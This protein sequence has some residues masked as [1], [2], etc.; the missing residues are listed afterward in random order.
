MREIIIN[1]IIVVFPL[2]IYFIYS[3]NDKILDLKT[4]NLLF[5]FCLFSSI[6]LLFNT[7]INIYLFLNVFLLISYYK[8]KNILS[9]IISIIIILYNINYNI[10]LIPFYIIIYLLYYLIYKNNKKYLSYIIIIT[11]ILIFIILNGINI[12]N[13]NIILS[14]IL[15]NILLIKLLNKID[16]IFN[17]YKSLDDIYNNKIITSSLF[18]ITHEIKNPLS[19]IKGYLDMYDISNINHSKK[20]IPIIKEEVDRT[21]LLL[22]DFLCINKLNMD[23]DILDINYLLEQLINSLNILFKKNNI[24][25]N[26]KIDDS[27]IYINGDYNRLTQVFINIFKNSVE[28]IESNGEIELTDYIEDNNVIIKIKDNGIG[29]KDIEK[30]KEPFFTTKINGTG[31][32]VP[33]S[34]E[35]INKHNGVINYESSSKGTIV[36]IKLPIICFNN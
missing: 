1:L 28:A 18:K 5:E 31:L 36:T 24:K 26:N 33:L 12:L 29:I 32:G 13:I 2:L 6:Y 10:I 4:N 34:I 11:S 16:N 7:N 27:E 19:V 23:L 21:I 17:I 14:Y 3:L 9:I 22:N 15:L 35:I 25:L 8:N 20:Y 30:I